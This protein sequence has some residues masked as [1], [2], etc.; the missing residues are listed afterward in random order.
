MGVSSTPRQPPVTPGAGAE[1]GGCGLPGCP[2]PPQGTR[3]PSPAQGDSSWHSRAIRMQS[4]RSCQA[5]L[6][7]LPA[8]FLGASSSP[9][10]PGRQ[11]P[12]QVSPSPAPKLPKRMGRAQGGSIPCPRTGLEDPTPVSDCSTEQGAGTGTPGALPAPPRS[13]PKL[14]AGSTLAPQRFLPAMWSIPAS[15]Q[16]RTPLAAASQP[17]ARPQQDRS[18]R[19]PCARCISKTS[20]ARNPARQG[21]SSTG[22]WTSVVTRLATLRLYFPHALQMIFLG[23]PGRE[24]CW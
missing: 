4:G 11:L 21:S 3:S 22:L 6:S 14:P 18:A 7:P 9:Q 17:L 24:L 13:H 23:P 2:H 8:A 1:G 10:G 20:H 16:P 12:P 5:H 19:P 15:S